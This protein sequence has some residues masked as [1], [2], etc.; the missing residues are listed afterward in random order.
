MRS[1]KQIVVV[2][3]SNTDMVIKTDSFPQPGET[4][5]GG[6]FFMFPGGKGANQ[7]VA[8][9]RLGGQVTFV[10]KVGHDIFGEKARQQFA[11]EGIAIE[12]VSMHPS[13][14]SG[15]ALITVDGKGENTIV[16]AQG[17]NGILSPQDVANAGTAFGQDTIVLMQLEIPLDTVV[18]A[19]Q[20][21]RSNGGF[22]ILN[23]APARTLP[24][25]LLKHVSLI[26]PNRTET[27]T[28]TGIKVTDTASAIQASHWFL[29]KGISS[30]I[31]TLGKDGA[32]LFDH[33]GGR[34]I[35]SP[36]V[37]A[38]DSTAAGDVFN[39]ALAVAL[40]EGSAID[41]AVM[42]ANRAAAISVTR[43]GAQS[44]APY[45]NEVSEN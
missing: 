3:S 22:V 42:R 36:K 29:D 12:H 5:L 26:T 27:E 39:G 8:A 20:L 10:A 16:V 38:I 14:P 32:F 17:S 19:A 7:A 40:A 31:I 2:G 25:E 21:S 23:P 37:K 43:M 18:F 11:K 45:R 41:E 4:L 9:S 24:D 33:T 1:P 28:L 44:S 35:G 30:V 15:V 34:L 6:E 13:L